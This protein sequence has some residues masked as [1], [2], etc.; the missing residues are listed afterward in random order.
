M[1]VIVLPAHVPVFPAAGVFAGNVLVIPGATATVPFTGFFVMLTVTASALQLRSQARSC[2]MRVSTP[3]SA[4]RVS[5]SSWAQANAAPSSEAIRQASETVRVRISAPRCNR[6]FR[7]MTSTI[8]DGAVAT[9]AT[10]G[11]PGAFRC[12]P[13]S[14]RAWGVGQFGFMS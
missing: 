13:Q 7:A 3:D 9:K 4:D 12:L 10:R 8:A 5:V 1:P 2:A 14:M 11:L 6:H